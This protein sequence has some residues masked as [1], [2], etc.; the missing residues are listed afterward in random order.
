MASNIL[1]KITCFLAVAQQVCRKETVA[2][3]VAHNQASN[4]T[5]VFSDFMQACTQMYQKL[6]MC[7]FD[8]P[9][10]RCCMCLK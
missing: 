2:L 6:N 1:G 3:H 7:N 9:H 5:H 4:C 8:M 10:K